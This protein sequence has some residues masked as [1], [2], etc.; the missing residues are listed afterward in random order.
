M[1]ESATFYTNKLKALKRFYVDLLELDVV[2]QSEGQMT[3]RVG[4][5]EVTFKET[6]QPAFYHFAFNIPGN[7]FSMMKYFIKDRLSLNW[8][9]GRDEVYFSSFNADSMYF[10]DP[11]GNIVELIG[12][13]KR[14][15]F[16]DLTKES[17]LNISEVGI[18]TP[19]VEGVGEQLLD[20][21][22][23]LRKGTDIHPDELNFLGRGD[24]YIVLVPPGRRWYFSKKASEVY[25]L[26]M[27]WNGKKIGIDSDGKWLK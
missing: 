5:S 17:F 9:D 10:E 26:E 6:E 7:Q 16:G 13:R 24:T 21:G 19:D 14:D 15:L 4:E 11:A 2:E 8:E 3:F 1:I 20:A 27:Y 23:P 22:I 25:P 12:R 18:V